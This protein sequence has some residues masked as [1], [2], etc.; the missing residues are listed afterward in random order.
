[1]KLKRW[2]FWWG[3]VFGWCLVIFL[4]SAIPTLPKVGFVWWDFVLKK[5]AHITEYAILFV[6]IVRAMVKSYQLKVPTLKII[7]IALVFGLLY[8]IS[9]EYHQ[10]LVMGRTS[11]ARDVGFDFLGML[12]SW[13]LLTYKRQWLDKIFP[14]TWF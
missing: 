6:L 11:R 9:D 5:T 3:P 8:A 7:I 13:Y 12:I 14:K 4:F 1:M 10:R 2:L